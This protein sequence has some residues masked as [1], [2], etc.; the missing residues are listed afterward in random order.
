VPFRHIIVN[1]ST[2]IL[3]HIMIRTRLKCY[4]CLITVYYAVI[5]GV[6]NNLEVREMLST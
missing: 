6:Y 5:T 1:M 2:L 4:S 3:W